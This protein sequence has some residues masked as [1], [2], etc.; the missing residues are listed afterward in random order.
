VAELEAE[1]RVAAADLARDFGPRELEHIAGLLQDEETS[2]SLWSATANC[3]AAAGV[4]E[5]APLLA[6]ALDPSTPGRRRTPAR[7]ALHELFGRWFRSSQEVAPYLTAIEAG[8]GTRLL[9][10]ALLAEEERKRAYLFSAL[11]ARPGTATSWLED[12]DPRIRSGVAGILARRLAVEGPEAGALVTLIAH[13]EG[14][15]D[16]RAFHETLGACLEVLERLEVDSPESLRLRALLIDL[17]GQGDDPRAPSV[18]LALARLPWRTQG[19][20]DLGHVLTA[21]DSLGALARSMVAAESGADQDDPD[22]LVLALTSARQVCLTAKAAGLGADLRDGPAR[23]GLLGLLLDPSFSRAVRAAAA[24]AL[25]LQATPQEI[26]PLVGVLSDPGAEPS[27]RHALLGALEELVLELDPGSE[28]V[29]QV[30]RA[31]AS[32]VASTDVD[33]RRR[34]LEW[35]ARDEAAPHRRALDPAFLIE[36]LEVETNREASLVLLGLIGRNGTPETLTRLLTAATFESLCSDSALL[37]GLVQTLLALLRQDDRLCFEVA[38]RLAAVRSDVTHVQC[39]RHSLALAAALSESQAYALTPAQHL[40]IAAWVWLALEAGEAPRQ[41]G[42]G[43]PFVARVLELHLPQSDAAAGGVLSAFE[44]AHLDARL[45]ADL[46]LFSGGQARAGKQ[47]VEA[48][49]QASFERASGAE[50]RWLVLRD[51]ARFRAATSEGVKALA[52]Y[53]RLVEGGAPAE[54]L[55]SL[56]DLRSAC[57][58]LERLDVSAGEGRI[59]TASES[60]AFH[61]RILA[62]PEWRAEPPAV[63]LKDLE[64]WVEAGLAAGRPD[65]VERLDEAFSNLPQAHGSDEPRGGTPPP[66]LGLTRE[67]EWLRTLWGLRERIRASLRALPRG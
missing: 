13:L 3:V 46:C 63:R 67:A 27:V 26:P 41:L 65:C 53:R 44:R 7:S 64:L 42:G 49:Y 28:T 50:E 30:N 33:L 18:A 60:W 55:L 8:A 23:D 15:E 57:D 22:G 54:A 62:R 66:W 38:A 35:L 52:D 37:D 24:A 31:V 2:P 45:R 19:A 4:Y 48:A 40:D 10:A 1:R 11:E 51:R 20:R 61:T 5:L 43:A 12:P 47:E 34:A 39:L 9:V 59:V 36:R 32:L 14:E 58:V 6:R 21:V 25:G 16:P 17:A 56:A 29:Q